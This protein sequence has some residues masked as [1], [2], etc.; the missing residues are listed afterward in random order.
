MKNEELLWKS[1]R[2]SVIQMKS[3]WGIQIKQIRKDLSLH[4]QFLIPDFPFPHCLYSL[5]A[6]SSRACWAWTM[7]SVRRST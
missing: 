7:A 1:S 2:I 6:V 4:S 3:K 5:S